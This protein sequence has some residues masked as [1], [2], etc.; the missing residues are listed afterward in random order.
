MITAR[1][2][3]TARSSGQW[4]WIAVAVSFALSLTR[5]GQPVLYPFKIFTTWI[6]ECGHALMA[7]LVGGRVSSITIQTNTSGLTESLIPATRLARA[8]VSSAGYMSASVVGCLLLAATRVEKSAQSILWGIGAFMLLTLLLWIRNPFGAAAVLA[9]GIAL[10]LLARHVTG[11]A[12]RFFVSFLAIQVALNAV[13]DIRVLF[14]VRGG[15]SDAEAMARVFPLP[16]W[17]WAASWM[18]V[19]VAMLMWTFWVTQGFRRCRSR[20]RG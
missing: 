4:L 17:V 9:W 1:G 10:I 3:S 20:G 2:A 12:S 18:A 13:Y 7:L 14:F 15:H 16:S 6:H 5:W 19:S 8:L 11:H